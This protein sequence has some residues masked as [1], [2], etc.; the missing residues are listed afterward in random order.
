MTRREQR[1]IATANLRDFRPLHRDLVTPGEAGHAGMVFVPSG[2]RLRS[3]DID[4]VLAGLEAL[5]RRVSRNV[6][7]TTGVAMREARIAKSW[8]SVANYR[9]KI[10]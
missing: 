4:R 3:D 10:A 7:V 2:F 8:S 5:L 1:V 9:S 6:L